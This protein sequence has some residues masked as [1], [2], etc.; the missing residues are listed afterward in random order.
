[1]TWARRRAFARLITARS[2][3]VRSAP[4]PPPLDLTRLPPLWRGWL[5][6]S[7]A[8]VPRWGRVSWDLPEGLFTYW[9][10][11]ILSWRAVP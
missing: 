11:E 2:D 3:A 8:L 4:A 6:R 5:E 9:E 10:G 7:G 1:L